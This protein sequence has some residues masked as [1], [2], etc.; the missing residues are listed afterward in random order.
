MPNSRSNLED[1]RCCVCLS[2]LTTS[3]KK[4][5]ATTMTIAYSEAL[6]NTY[7][8]NHTALLIKEE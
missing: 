4:R 6:K 3:K 1:S 7:A 8:V 5:S 2:P